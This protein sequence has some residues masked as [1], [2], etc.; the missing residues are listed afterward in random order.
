M[1][2]VGMQAEILRLHFAE[3][4]SHRA[5][6]QQLGVHRKTVAQVVKNKRVTPSRTRSA[7]PHASLLD[8]YKSRIDEL[9]EQVPDRSA[10]NILQRLREQGYLGGIAIL[11]RHV[12][13]VRPR[14]KQRPAYLR[15]SFHPGEAAQVDWG[16]FGDVFGIGS[17]VSVLVVVLCWSRMLYLEFALRQNLPSLLRRYERA[18][19]F[20]GGPAREMWHDNMSTVVAKRHGRLVRFTEGFLAYAGYRHFKPVACNVG[21]GHEKGRIEDGVKLVRHQFWPGRSFADIDDLNAQAARWRDTFANR[22]QHATTRKIPELCW[23][24]EKR[25]LLSLSEVPY[26]TDDVVSAVVSHQC[27]V[28]FDGNTYSVPWTLSEKTVT[29]RADDATVRICYGAHVVARHHRDYR[30]GQDMA[31]PAHEA[32]LRDIKRQANKPDDLTAIA[33]I[34]PKTQ[35]FFELAFAGQRSLRQESRHLLGLATVYGFA[36]VET[37]SAALLEQGIIGSAYLE[38]ALRLTYTE[39]TAPEPLCLQN[40]R[41]RRAVP[42]PALESYDALLF[43]GPS[44]TQTPDAPQEIDADADTP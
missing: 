42:R 18:L 38:R 10:V 35:R 9:L 5:I 7:A 32:G 19:A 4:L 2:A 28:H 12:K 31:N 20:F 23:E 41:L 30:K 6:A 22:R 1:I 16:E 21:A 40:E 15:L 34:G 3:R 27:R 13:K 25:H 39:H 33:A 37:Q 8:P 17:K 11:R 43:A 36:A 24:Q 26:E 44:A 14:P 29:V